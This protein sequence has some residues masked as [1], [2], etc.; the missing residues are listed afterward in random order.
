M[1][2]L[3]AL[4]CKKPHSSHTYC[5]CGVAMLISHHASPDA[6]NI[7]LLASHSNCSTSISSSEAKQGTGACAAQAGRR[8]VNTAAV[9]L[10]KPPYSPS[11]ALKT[12]VS[13]I[14]YT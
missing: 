10:D 14:V 13:W 1:L 2:A 4:R 12:S 9:R 3:S 7:Y 8:V 6:V 11:N 5:S